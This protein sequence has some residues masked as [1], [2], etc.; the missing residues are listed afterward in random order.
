MYD[1]AIIGLG[2]MGSATAY[3][4]ATRGATVIGFDRFAPPHMLGSTHGRTRIIREAYYEHPLYV[5]LIRR[6]YENWA[7]LEHDAGERLLHVTG[8]LM[9]GHPSGE[10]VAGAERSAIAH[11]I[12]HE[13]LDAQ[14]LHR[15]FPVFRPDDGMVALHEARAGLL[16]PEACI[17]AC[18]RLA[19]TSGAELRLAEPAREWRVDRNSV[20]VHT[21]DG[22]YHARRLVISAGAWLPELVPDVDLPLRVERQMF[23]WFTPASDAASLHATRCPIALWEFEPGRLF[24]TFPDLGDGVKVG[25][26]HEGEE[27]TPADVRRTISAAEDASVRGLLDRYMP[28]AAGELRESRVCL[29]TNT[30]DHDFLIDTHPAHPAVTMASPCSGHGFK[31]ASVMGEI[32]A[33]LATD[34]EPGF[35]LS[36]FRLTGRRATPSL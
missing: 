10:L 6:A 19:R 25:I 15:R 20:V 7:T 21:D 13:M 24:A 32:L 30:P 35:D 34:R 29:Y 27:T 3:H 4:L 2:A 14:S 22:E 16:L 17:D 33:D 31:F 26:H 23:H 1:V 9:I 11:Q 5:P 28:A 36:P 18:L 12:A 8:G